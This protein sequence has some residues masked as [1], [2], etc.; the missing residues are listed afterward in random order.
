MYVLRLPSVEIHSWIFSFWVI[1]QGVLTYR[2][3]KP[4]R[5]VGIKNSLNLKLWDL[6][7]TDLVEVKL[8]KLSTSTVSCADIGTMLPTNRYIIIP[9]LMK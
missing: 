7:D 4:K 5:V 6:Q 3:D 9:A 8:F 1:R 2:A